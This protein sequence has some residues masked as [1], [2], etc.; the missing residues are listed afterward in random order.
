MKVNIG[1]Y[2]RQSWS[3]SPFTDFLERVGIINEYNFAFCDDL[4]GEIERGINKVLDIFPRKEKKR[5]IDIVIDGY[6]TWDICH[7]ISL[8]ITPLLREYRNNMHGYGIVDKSDTPAHIKEGQHSWEWVIDEMIWT[9]EQY[10]SDDDH[11][12]FH[13]NI[14]QLKPLYTPVDEDS[15]DGLRQLNFD[16]QKD[17]SK[18]PY[19]FDKKGLE[20]HE[21][22]KKNGLRLFAKYFNGLWD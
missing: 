1:P 21:K 14:D 6:D 13:K 8:I 19:S 20:R 22:R 10:A 5:K 17:K 18:E 9:F 4:F 7:T 11:D 2:P 15:P 3:I 16:Y 12:Q